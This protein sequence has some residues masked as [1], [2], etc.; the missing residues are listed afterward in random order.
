MNSS[1]PIDRFA[2]LDV[3][4]VLNQEPVPRRDNSGT[5]DWLRATLL[6]GLGLTWGGITSVSM[7]FDDQETK[8][9]AGALL[10]ACVIAFLVFRNAIF[11]AWLDSGA[12]LLLAAHVTSAVVS[13][14]LSDCPLES[15]LRYAALLP[16]F[17]LLLSVARG[18]TNAV[19]KVRLGL[20]I[21][22]SAFVVFHLTELDFGSIADPMYRI[23]I[24]LNTNSTA[25]I[26]S[27]TALS[28]VELALRPAA[29]N[30]ARIFWF[31][32]V[33]CCAVVLFGTKSRTALL[34]MISGSFVFTYIRF[35]TRLA[36]TATIG[37]IVLG[38]S[39][40]FQHREAII[41][42]MSLDEKD[43]SIETGTGRYEIWR[44]LSASVISKNP[45]LGIG[46]GQ[47]QEL[48]ATATGSSSA[49]NGLIASLSETGVIGTLP[50]LLIIIWCLRM[51]WQRRVPTGQ[52]WAAPLFVAGIV[53]SLGESIL[54]SIGNP[55][56][57]LFML[58][59]AKLAT[60]LL[61]AA[62][63]RPEIDD[64]AVPAEILEGG[65]H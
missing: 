13:G 46:P 49:H 45:W 26:T 2:D 33:L 58:A 43:R 11:L 5:K 3:P 28:A 39:Y 63:N 16:A 41:Y 19:E 55:A 38:A 14:L 7:A 15:G 30:G 22:G 8:I 20:T 36:R 59:V 48:V 25:F 34:A 40:A 50:L 27:M 56:S 4:S 35:S 62:Q 21:A 23:T 17:S 31:S 6:I 1:Q 47:H 51:A 12:G 54:F 65:L 18:E 37:L 44:F 53:E 61:T 10:V 57:L 60:P 52:A 9:Q 24:Y 32:V 29:R 64:E 42:A